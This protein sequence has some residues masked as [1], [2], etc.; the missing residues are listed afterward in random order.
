M[1]ATEQKDDDTPLGRMKR[2]RDELQQRLSRLCAF[3]DDRVEGCEVLKL[4]PAHR[5]LLA[6]QKAVMQE[7]RDI[8]DVRVEMMESVKPDEDDLTSITVCASKASGTW[9]V[10]G[11]AVQP[12]AK[13]K[14]FGRLL[15]TVKSFLDK[16]IDIVVD[17]RPKKPL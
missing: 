4:S 7:Y 5:I 2:E 10:T 6:R 14:P 1:E 16:N 15:K 9:A 8:L 17:A 13:G 12:V 11:V 3:M